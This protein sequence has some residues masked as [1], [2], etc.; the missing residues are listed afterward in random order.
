MPPAT[1]TNNKIMTKS[2]IFPSSRK[3]S[4]I[5]TTSE[6]PNVIKNLTNNLKISFLVM[7]TPFFLS[8]THKL[9]NSKWFFNFLFFVFGQILPLLSIL[10]PKWFFLFLNF[11]E[12]LPKVHHLPKI[13]CTLPNSSLLVELI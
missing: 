3:P 7:M 5:N 13:Q 12:L 10:Y 1:T 9:K 6:K 4:G 11:L 2:L 8:I